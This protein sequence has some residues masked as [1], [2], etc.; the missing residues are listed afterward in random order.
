MM[1]I[2]GADTEKSAALA[3]GSI[4]EGYKD[5]L[6]Y[7]Q[8]IYSGETDVDSREIRP[9]VYF[10]TKEEQPGLNF[11]N[12]ADLRIVYEEEPEETLFDLVSSADSA[13]SLKEN[14]SSFVQTYNVK[15]NA[16]WE[17][18][19]VEEEFNIIVETK[20]EKMAATFLDFNGDTGYAVMGEN[21]TLY[22]LQIEGESPFKGKVFDKCYYSE[23]GGYFYE[24]DSKI[25]SADGCLESDENTIYGKS[26]DGQEVGSTGCG[27]IYDPVQYIQSRYGGTWR[28]DDNKSLDMK[29]YSQWDL[30]CYIENTLKNGKI[31]HCSEGNCWYISAYHVL[32]YFADK[33]WT[34]APKST[35]KDVSYNA[36]KNE[37]NTYST[38]FD[39]NGKAKSKSIKDSEGNS[40]FQWVLAKS[41]GNYSFPELYTKVRKYADKSYKLHTGGTNSSTA[42]VIKGVAAMYGHDVKLSVHYFW[43]F[44][45]EKAVD[46]IDQGLPVIWSTS[47]G[48]YGGHSMAVCGY[49]YYTQRKRF[50][51]FS[52]VKQKLFYE[53]RDGHSKEA[54]FYDMSGFVGIAGLIF[55]D[56]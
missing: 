49:Q 1:E 55:I 48:T 26:Y 32:Q 18:V 51:W 5:F 8:L 42:K 53:L 29:G 25:V 10:Y 40:T 45:K 43:F 7:S 17:A 41:S 50:L 35:A 24:Q 21:Y 31:S 46:K 6:M 44:Y 39:A 4:E 20:A 2:D 23:S 3:V 16:D 12:Q 11:I 14:L 54:R 27:N 52:S 15:E 28:L 13:E 36:A 33:K 22:D 47:T 30:S 38:L 19:S 56:G 9:L 34:N 37:P